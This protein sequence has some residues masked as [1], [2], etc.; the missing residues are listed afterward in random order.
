M[1]AFL[2]FTTEA[3]SEDD[4]VFVFFAG[5]GCTRTGR[6]GEVGYLVPVDGIPDDV[7]SLVRWDDL[8]R[9][10]DWVPAKHASF[11]MDACYGGLAVTRAMAPGASRFLKDMLRR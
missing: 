1:S 10:A 2:R 8:T 11:V 7:S 6:R 9:N 4:R 3:A 5:H